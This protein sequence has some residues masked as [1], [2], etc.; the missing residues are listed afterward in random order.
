MRRI[1]WYASIILLTITGLI[2]LWQFRQALL[3]F[4]LSLAIAAAFR[5][6]IEAFIQ[7]GLP[8]NLSLLLAYLIILGLTIGVLWL[9]SG[10]LIRD[11][12]QATN[13]FATSYERILA[14]WPESGVPFQR[15]LASQLPP[16]DELFGGV[17]DEQSLQGLMGVTTDLVSFCGQPGIDFDFEPVL[18]RR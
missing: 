7:R 3:L 14:S 8:R 10:P 17:A 1:G 13:H 2:I 6:L 18:E 11:I 4:V 9:V 15:M 16:P 5:P 12:E